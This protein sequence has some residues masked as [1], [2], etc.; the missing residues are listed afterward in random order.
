V[1]WRHDLWN[2]IGESPY[3]WDHVRKAAPKLKA[4][5]HPIGIGQSQELDSDM[6]LIA[7]LMCFGSFIQNEHNRPAMNVK[8]TVNAVKFMTEIYKTGEDSSIFAW[9]PASNNQGLVSGQLSL[10]LNAIS[11][12]RTPESLHL[13]FAD[14][15]W[16]W[17]IP[18][19]PHGR[20]GLEHLMGCW[21]IWKFAKNKAN[22]QQ[23]LVDLLLQAKTATIQSQLY[24]FPT[25]A[26][27]F[28][29][30]QINKFAAKDPNKPHGKYTVLTTIA[31]KYT[32]NIGWPGTVNAAMS[33]V[34]ATYLIPQ[35][36]AQV[37][38]G[39]MSAADS[40]SSTVKRINAI[41]KKWEKRGKI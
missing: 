11:A 38:Q 33:E 18:I 41:Y 34:F 21:N 13:P 32:H 37:S 2:G 29:F 30:K 10:I 19:G 4:I 26:N 31:Q 8:N 22:A 3:T 16:I 9:N 20:Y 36:F 23:F 17:P 6:A 25:F 24:N 12:T 7:F 14:D 27:A 35:M 28:P 39:K 5:G 1:V 40:V 15:L